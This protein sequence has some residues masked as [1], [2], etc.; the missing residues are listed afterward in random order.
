METSQEIPYS[1]W[2]KLLHY[3]PGTQFIWWL[4][5]WQKS[6]WMQIFAISAFTVMLF[7]S[8]RSWSLAVALLVSMYLH[9][10]G[11]AIVFMVAGI[12]C[13]IKVLFPLGAVAAPINK[14]ED[15]RSDRL[16]WNTTSWLMQA[17]PAVNVILLLV[18]FWIKNMSDPIVV[19]FGRDL[20]LINGVL[21]I[22]NLLP[23][24]KLD[25]GQLYR[26]I[27]SSLDEQTDRFVAIL[28]TILVGFLMFALFLSPLSQGWWIFMGSL[29]QF[30]AW[31]IF[32]LLMAAGVW[33]QQ[34]KDNPVYA[35]SAQRMNKTQVSIQIVFYVGMAI[36]TLWIFSGLPF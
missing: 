32:P 4:I 13:M 25:A 28:V 9:E 24:G 1:W 26:Q 27:F 19:Q 6:W 2:R 16:P 8:F 14:E 29:I 18:G 12:K 34:A 15:E 17:G 11:H 22:S 3:P 36:T 21:A 31:W 30:A 23:I 5:G 20:V 7:L 10:A 33:H 35:T